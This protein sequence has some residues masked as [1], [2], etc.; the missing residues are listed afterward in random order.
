[1]KLRDL[2]YKHSIIYCLDVDTF[3]DGNGDGVGD[4]E[5]LI[6]RLDKLAGLGITCIWLMP[7]YPT[8]NRDNGYDVT[9]YYNVDPRLG[10]LGDFV[11]F[12]T[13]AREHGIRII[14]DLVVNHTSIDHPWFQ[15]ARRDPNSRYRD[16]YVWSKEK[17]DNAHEGVVFPG[18]QNTTWTYDRKAGMYYFHR[19]YKHQ[20]DLNISNPAVQAEICKI[21]GFWLQ[22]GVSGFRIDAAPFLIE[23][24]GVEPPGDQD[25]HHYL[26]AFRNF[27]SWRR[28]DA[29]MLAEANVEM[30]KVAEYFGRGDRMHM[31]FHFL[32][33][34]K[35]YLA[36]A[37]KDAR[38]LIE[39]LNAPPPIPDAS[40]WAIFVRNHDELSLDKLTEAER[41]EVFAAFGSDP[42]MQIYDRGIRRRL[43][44]ML[45]GNLDR[46]KLVYSLL[47]ALPGTPVLYYGQEIGMGE[48]L[49]LEER[50]SVRTPMQWSDEKNGG[51]STAPPEKLVR[52]VIDKGGFGY[53]QVNF[54]DQNRR[55][56]SLLSWMRQMISIRK[57]C[58]EIGFGEWEI[59]ETGVSTAFAHRCLWDGGCVLMVHNFADEP[60]TVRLSLKHLD[61]E[62]LIDL[63]GHQVCE[64]NQ[65]GTYMMELH[66]YGFRW[67]RVRLKEQDGNHA[68]QLPA[69]ARYPSYTPEMIGNRTR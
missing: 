2:W 36:L 23:L 9:D 65:D 22:L 45:E 42:E 10:T 20:A 16:Y 24:K 33:N 25:Q 34:Q 47:F 39:G 61:V 11:E 31:L 46:M 66:P 41:Q 18:V 57:E 55:S 54:I 13:R 63:L 50:N 26:E 53:K 43:A 64:L 44:S 27:L 69:Q 15:A 51:F 1:M 17:P 56:D 12:A 58:P 21:M 5:G 37:R 19:F 60:V 68:A 3:Q 62:H 30:D 49:S 35:L 6:N 7:F 52:P 14:V 48:D 67:F 59:L 40:Q 29:I 28:G 8:P 4:F 32:L 38:P